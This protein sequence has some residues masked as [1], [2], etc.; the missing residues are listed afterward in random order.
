VKAHT[1]KRGLSGVVA[2]LLAA[3]DRFLSD[4]GSEGCVAKAALGC[5]V[6]RCR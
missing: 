6:S 3:F 4:P 2:E 1:G 5:S